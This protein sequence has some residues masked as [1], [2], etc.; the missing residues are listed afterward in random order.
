MERNSHRL[1]VRVHTVSFFLPSHVLG[2]ILLLNWLAQTKTCSKGKN[3][4][5]DEIIVESSQSNVTVNDGDAIAQPS[6]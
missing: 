6:T 5:P 4:D 1:H 2:K 3:T